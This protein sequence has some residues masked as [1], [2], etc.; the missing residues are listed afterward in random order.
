LRVSLEIHGTPP[1]GSFVD[2]Q[3]GDGSAEARDESGTV[4][5]SAHTG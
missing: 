4:V 1:V 5:A 2:V 3:A